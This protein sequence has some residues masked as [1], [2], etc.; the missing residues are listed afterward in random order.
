MDGYTRGF[1]IFFAHLP[2]YSESKPAPRV[3][4]PPCVD[5]CPNG[6]IC[7]PTLGTTPSSSLRK[8]ETMSQVR[9]VYHTDVVSVG[10]KS[11]FE[12]FLYSQLSTITPLARGPPAS[13]AVDDTRRFNGPSS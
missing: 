11:R 9:D 13:P 12:L 1:V 5:E 2:K 7:H 6:S 3:I 10:N 8:Q 4:N